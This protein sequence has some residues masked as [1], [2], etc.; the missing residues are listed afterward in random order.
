MLNI[1][2]KYLISAFQTNDRT[3]LKKASN[4]PIFDTNGVIKYFVEIDGV[5]Y[6]KDGVLINFAEI[7]YLDPC[8]D[9]KLFCIVY[10][11]EDLLQ[12][13]VSYTGM[14]NFVPYPNN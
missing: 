10:V 9:L 1:S 6:N 11:G 8:R 12:P 14:K 2:P 5:R 7:S 13:Y 3:T 4:A